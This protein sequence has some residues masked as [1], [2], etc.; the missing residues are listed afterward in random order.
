[1]HVWMID[2]DEKELILAVDKIKAAASLPTT[3]TTNTTMT[4]TTTDS[5][6]DST[7]FQRIEYRVVDVS[8]YQAMIQL[9][10][11]VFDD[12][13]DY[14]HILMNNAGIGL[15]GGAITTPLDT[16]QHV[17]NVNTYGPIHGCLAFVPKMKASQQ[18]GIIINTGSKQGITMPPGNLI[19]N[20][21]KAAL[22]VYTEGLEHEFMLERRNKGSNNNNNNSDRKSLLRAALL[23]PGWV[24]TSIVLKAMR[25]QGDDQD[26]DN[27]NNNDIPFHE[28]KPAAGAWMPYQV[29]DYM[30]QQLDLGRFYIVCP[31]HDVTRHMDNLRMTWTMQD[32][33]HNRPPLSRWHPNYQEEY[34]QYLQENNNNNNDM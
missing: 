21:S 31:D 9:A 34:N 27:N 23:I 25:V 26:N 10:D 20:M 32:I 15:G 5:K 24:N 14:C 19:Y 3:C 16:I 13:D 33:T 17:M 7:T 30:I 18:P 29:I 4:T 22:K 11:Q 2:I 1:M 8:N 12:D 28:D 6:L